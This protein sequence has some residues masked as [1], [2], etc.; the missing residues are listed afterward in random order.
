MAEI[1]YEQQKRRLSYEKITYLIIGMALLFSG[2]AWIVIDFNN[3]FLYPL[4]K[5]LFFIFAIILMISVGLLFGLIIYK[6]TQ[7]FQITSYGITPY[8][9]PLKSL[10]T[11]DYQIPWENV[12]HIV[13]VEDDIIEKVPIL[14]IIYKENLEDI[15]YNFND[16]NM[17]KKI[18]SDVMAL[19]DVKEIQNRL[20]S[21]QSSSEFNSW[22]KDNKFKW[23]IFGGDS[24]S[25]K[26]FENMGGPW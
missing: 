1:Y 7:R 21:F 15:R 14:H 19:L 25:L 10:F 9:K 11:K 6:T 8:R 17:Y 24:N 20:I 4:W 12:F 13:Y 22:V 2:I 23:K 26:H 16:I 18:R 5:T 3:F